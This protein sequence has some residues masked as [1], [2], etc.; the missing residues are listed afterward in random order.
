MRMTEENEEEQEVYARAITSSQPAFENG[1][2]E[3]AWAVGG[4]TTRKSVQ[5]I[6]E[7]PSR[8]AHL[9]RR[10]DG[11]VQNSG[12]KKRKVTVWVNGTLYK[13]SLQPN[14]SNRGIKWLHTGR[15]STRSTH[16]ESPS[17]DEK[18]S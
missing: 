16:T 1:Q 18:S 17:S 11:Q 9:G 3:T 10:L 7:V 4:G 2:I 5:A 8:G 14:G 12:W 6:R 15:K 13:S